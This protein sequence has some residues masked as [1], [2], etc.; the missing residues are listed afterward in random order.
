MSTLRYRTLF[1]DLDGPLADLAGAIN[2]TLGREDAPAEKLSLR[3]WQMVEAFNPRIF[4]DLAPAKD[5]KKLHNL[6][7]YY[8]PIILTAVPWVV[9]FKHSSEDKR[10]W[11][12]EHIG[13]Y[14]EVRFGPY[15][16]DKQYHCKE[17]DILVDDSA[18]NIIQ[19][20]KAGGTG[21][22]YKDF[23]S[24]KEEWDSF[25]IKLRS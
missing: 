12:K 5:M 19:W 10:H 1:L 24:F 8:N 3:E 20:E 22:L 25:V 13:E 11:V 17:G 7:S 6:L 18:T 14:Q 4:R 9:A 15:A 21:F 2:K 23:P 16:I